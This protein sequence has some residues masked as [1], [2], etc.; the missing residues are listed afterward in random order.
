[1]YYISYATSMILSMELWEKSQSDYGA[2]RNAYFSILQR[3]PYAKLRS[4]AAQNGLSD[5]LGEGTI[6]HLA[7]TL[8][9][10]F[11]RG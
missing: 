4:T 10:Y 3:K 6:E 7:D 9:G 11:D 2:A 1:M 8:A 5:P